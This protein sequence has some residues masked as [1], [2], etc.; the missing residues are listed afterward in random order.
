MSR[1]V[2]IVGGGFGGVRTALDLHK[3]APKDLDIW[4]IS[5]KPHLEYH[6]SLHRV[7]SGEPYSLVRIPLREIFEDK[8]HVIQD[9]ITQ[10]DIHNKTVRGA[11][12]TFYQADFLVLALGSQTTFHGIP[13]L[14]EL[15]FGLKS[16]PDA[17][18]LNTHLK[19]LFRTTKAAIEED[20]EEFEEEEDE[21]RIYSMHIVIIG[22][23][24][25]GTE[26][27]GELAVYTREL[28][29]RSNIDPSLIT[30]DLVDSG[31]RILK[32]LPRDISAKVQRRLRLLDVNL[33]L[34]RRVVKEE[35]RDIY[36]KDMVLKTLT[37]IWAA[38]VEPNGLYSR[39][40]GLSLD[41]TRRV[42]VDRFLQPNALTDIFVIGDGAS[43]TY[44]GTA[45]SAISQ[46]RYVAE[47]IIR[48]IYRRELIP[49]TVKKPAH[50]IPVGSRWAAVA[51][52]RLRFYGR[53]GWWLRQFA[54]LRF[55]L[56]ILPP[57]KAWATFTNKSKPT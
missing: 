23:G 47:V 3:R 53:V 18:R 26:L 6:P 51:I 1:R 41:K 12:G 29:K 57:R 28:A 31:P 33:F 24:E 8:I 7:V 27:A 15:A 39:I 52:G 44:S 16:I 11:S 4:L 2:V 9:I 30:I 34:N 5:D 50:A 10:V 49:Y 42:L 36:L 35:I 19:E 43:T 54:N 21:R 38:G 13:G 17:L 32:R 22:A 37:V 55:F 20:V 40:E 46:G 25:T 14:K 56:S 45:Q 48:R